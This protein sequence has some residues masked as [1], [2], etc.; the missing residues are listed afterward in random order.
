MPTVTQIMSFI[1]Y[2]MLAA[3]NSSQAELCVTHDI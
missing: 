1:M 3:E 2:H